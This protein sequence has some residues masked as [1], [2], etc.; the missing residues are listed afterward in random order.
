MSHYS[1]IAEFLP[2]ATA[3]DINNLVRSMA[4]RL[5]MDRGMVYQDCYKG[6]ADE[7]GKTLSTLKGVHRVTIVHVAETA[8][9]VFRKG[10][11]SP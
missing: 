5:D 1:I 9:G 7:V 10:R 3:A 6:N 11:K 4:G 2:T 8:H